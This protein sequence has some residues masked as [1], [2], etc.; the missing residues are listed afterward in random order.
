V[1]ILYGGVAYREDQI[2]QF[3]VEIASWDL[4]RVYP[5]PIACPQGGVCDKTYTLFLEIN[6]SEQT[7]N[8]YVGLVLQ[9]MEHEGCENHPPFVRINPR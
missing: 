7:A 2:D 5:H 3:T 1:P 9:A 6:A 8:E 4:T